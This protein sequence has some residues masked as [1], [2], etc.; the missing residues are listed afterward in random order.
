MFSEA[1]PALSLVFCNINVWIIVSIVFYQSF[2]K[3]SLWTTLVIR[4]T[5]NMYHSWFGW[6][7]YFLCRLFQKYNFRPLWGPS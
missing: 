1:L 2:A 4:S 6:E 3:V 7:K 5:I